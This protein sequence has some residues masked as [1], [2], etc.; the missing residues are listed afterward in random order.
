MSNQLYFILS[1][2]ALTILLAIIEKY[3][4][5]ANWGEIL[6]I[7]HSWSGAGAI[8]AF[9]LLLALF[10]QW[11]LYMICIGICCW[12]IRGIFY[13]PALNLLRGEYIDYESD[14]TTSKTDK[15]EKKRKISFWMQRLLYF[16]LAAAGYGLYY[17]AILIFK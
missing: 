17:V 7:K 10:N 5:K 12:G 16:L 14:S 4:I 11:N 3:R 8:A 6:N 1:Y 13:D 9:I 15:A 2:A